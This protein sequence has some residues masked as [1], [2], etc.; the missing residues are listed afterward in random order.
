MMKR[1]SCC[2]EDRVLLVNRFPVQ[3]DVMDTEQHL[4]ATLPAA[5]NLKPCAS[6][7]SLVLP[8]HTVVMVMSYNQHIMACVLVSEVL[9]L[10][11]TYPE[12]YTHMLMNDDSHTHVN[13]NGTYTFFVRKSGFFQS[14]DA[15]M[16]VSILPLILLCS[17]FSLIIVQ[18][19]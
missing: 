16:K 18:Y 3:M 4:S 8:K 9:Q 10:L 17:L 1:H 13:G 15:K 6:T 19:Q 11:I 2:L 12:G 7:A 14:K 5:S